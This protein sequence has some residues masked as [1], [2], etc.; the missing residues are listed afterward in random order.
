MVGTK[1]AEIKISPK[2]TTIITF[3]RLDSLCLC[4]H[5]VDK[6]L[7]IEPKYMLLQSMGSQRVRHNL[8]TK[9]QYHVGKSVYGKH[10]TLNHWRCLSFQKC[11]L[12][13]S[14]EVGLKNSI[15]PDQV[16]FFASN[17]GRA[18][19]LLILLVLHVVSLYLTVHTVHWTQGS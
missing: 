14:Y 3:H 15:H 9:Q 19:V 10:V 6:T 2:D 12:A 5:T 8:V 13:W 11:D 7:R 16:D 4:I 18:D 1:P 17:F